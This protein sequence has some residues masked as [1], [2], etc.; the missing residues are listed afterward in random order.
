[1]GT[2]AKTAVD[3]KVIYDDTDIFCDFCDSYSI[4]VGLFQD[5]R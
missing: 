1:M 4:R 5:R 3:L 2:F